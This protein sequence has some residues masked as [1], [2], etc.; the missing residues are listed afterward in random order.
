M[1]WL[2][3]ATR[4]MEIVSIRTMTPG[5]ITYAST[6]LLTLVETSAPSQGE[7]LALLST[8]KPDSTFV[9]SQAAKLVWV[10]DVLRWRPLEPMPRRTLVRSSNETARLAHGNSELWK[11]PAGSPPVVLVHGNPACTPLHQV[12]LPVGIR[13]LHRSRWRMRQDPESSV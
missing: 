2:L 12:C 3:L 8:I 10:T 5:R 11:F 13:E 7:K 4:E 1:E 9:S 6:W